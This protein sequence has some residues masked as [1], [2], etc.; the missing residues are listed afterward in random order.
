MVFPTNR[1]SEPIP[2]TRRRDITV[3]TTGV[4]AFWEAPV[5]NTGELGRRKPTIPSV[6]RQATHLADDQLIA[7]LD[8]VHDD[9]DTWRMA[10]N[11]LTTHIAVLNKRGEILAV[12]DAWRRFSCLEGDGSD[13]VGA[14]YLAVCKAA[15]DPTASRIAHGLRDVASGRVEQFECE[16]PCHSP[17]EERWFVIR[18]TRVT[19][20]SPAHIVV[21]HDNVTERRLSQE[22][23]LFH[24]LLLDEV[25]V[26]VHTVDLS[27]AV[28]SWNAGAE[29][30]YGWTADEVIGRP[31]DELIVSSE[32]PVAHEIRRRIGEGQWEGD[33]VLARKDGSTFSAHVRSRLIED[34]PGHEPLIVAVT[35][36]MSERVRS[37]RQL[38]LARDNLR[39]VTDSLG[40]GMFT[41]D[42]MGHVTYMNDVARSHLGWTA[43]ELYG[44]DFHRVTHRRRRD[45]SPMPTDECQIM[46][47]CQD[48]EIIEVDDDIFIN[49]DGTE[50]EVAYTVAPFSTNQDVDGCVI[51]FRDVA[52]RNT[53]RRRMALEA[54]KLA[55]IKQIRNAL[56]DDRFVLFAQPIVQLD[57][58]NVV[59]QELLI[60]MQDPESEGGVISPRA[61]LPVAEEFGLV[62]EIDQWV[63][64][65]AAELAASGFPVELNV[66]GASI[67]DPRLL[68][69]IITALERSGADPKNLVFEITE[70]TL[71]AN[72]TAGHLF[73]DR[74]HELGCGV[75]LDDFGTGYGGFTYIKQLPIEIVK[76]DIEFVRD[77]TINKASRNVVEAIVNLAHGFEVLTVAEGVEDEETLLLLRKLG[78][79]HAQGYYL[80]R[81]APIDTS[82]AFE[83]SGAQ[84]SKGPTT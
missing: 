26:A 82:A 7:A 8:L 45:A 32:T 31:A 73:V 52:A 58:G 36:D 50:R 12:N 51:V 60:R 22:R 1:V 48:H 79:D 2:L 59:Q 23:A 74:L 37:E 15:V 53:E 17:D 70:T 54:G 78:V 55:S 3:I 6:A 11:S 27:R 42:I 28:Q 33:L 9:N 19:S 30:L 25:D 47:A 77:L 75:A 10:A 81:P 63:I 68:Q 83:A 84:L 40:E 72:E 21:S 18:A 66:S 29:R 65:Q 44:E 14:N 57:S 24:S 20:S 56:D 16:Y 76:I 34:L 69:H 80:G 64:D 39:A 38:K 61:F 46:R 4:Y 41:I 49:A 71:I 5:T 43:A 35:M 13:Y 62:V 67:G